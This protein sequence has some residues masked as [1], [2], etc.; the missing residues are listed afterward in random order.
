MKNLS[1]DWLLP[2][3]SCFSQELYFNVQACKTIILFLI[4]YSNSAAKRYNLFIY[5]QYSTCFTHPSG[6]AIMALQPLMEYAAE[7]KPQTVYSLPNLKGGGYLTIDE[8]LDLILTNVLGMKDEMISMKTD[9]AHLKTDMVGVKA[10]MASMATEM[11]GVKA[12][13][14]SMKADI[15]DLKEDMQNVKQ[16][17]TNVE[18]TLE[19]VTNRNITIIAEGHLNLVRKL[20]EALKVTNEQEMLMVQVNF[21]EDEL[22]KLRRLIEQT[23]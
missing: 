16:R 20:D 21:H 12:S 11:N 19:N 14:V 13:M 23:A 4:L 15:A 18:M 9:I 6:Y 17:L 5:Q 7:A 1:R 10:N 3:I 22:R 2:V 8:K